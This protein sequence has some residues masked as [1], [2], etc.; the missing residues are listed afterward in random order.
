MSIDIRC[1][2]RR[3]VSFVAVFLLG[4]VFIYVSEHPIKNAIKYYTPYYHSSYYHS[5]YYH[6]PYYHTPYYVNKIVCK[7]EGEQCYM[8][9]DEKVKNTNNAFPKPLI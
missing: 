4:T 2:K 3:F 1:F 7:N 8:Y 5:P 6:S 9:N